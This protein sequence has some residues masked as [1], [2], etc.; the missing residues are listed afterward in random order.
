MK[1]LDIELYAP[2]PESEDEVNGSQDGNTPLSHM[3]GRVLS[4]QNSVRSSDDLVTKF[5]VPLENR[6]E[7]PGALELEIVPMCADCEGEERGK[8]QRWDKLW[9]CMQVRNLDGGLSDSRAHMLRKEKK[10]KEE[11]LD[12]PG[13]QCLKAIAKRERQAEKQVKVSPLLKDHVS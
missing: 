3:A 6:R 12:Q 1:R 13:K 9:S 4:R 11:W 7:R 2:L 8:K 10:P 5:F